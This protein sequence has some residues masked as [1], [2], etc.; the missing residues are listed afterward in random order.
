MYIAGISLS[1]LPAKIVLYK[2]SSANDKIDQLNNLKQAWQ[3]LESRLKQLRSDLRED[4]M[5]LDVLEDAL[6]TGTLSNHILSSLKDIEKLLSETQI[7]VNV[8]N[9]ISS[10]F[11]FN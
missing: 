7:Q 5:T 6:N 10:G 11:D 8:W 1:I 2:I 9:G 3:M 4:K